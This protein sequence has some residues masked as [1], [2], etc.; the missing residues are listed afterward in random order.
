M[1]RTE[2]RFSMKQIL[3]AVGIL[4]TALMLLCSLLGA[5]IM[6]QVI[7]PEFGQVA[8]RVLAIGC[9]F[10]VCWLTAQRAP[11]KRMY[12]SLAVGA[13]AILLGLLCKGLLFPEEPMKW[14]AVFL[15]LVAAAGAGLAAGRK[16]RRR[17]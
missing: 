3:I 11:Q 8:A 14:S 6:G 15:P 12:V 1:T 7:R 4:V 2:N 16:K 17:R 5:L 13:A 9:V 10:A